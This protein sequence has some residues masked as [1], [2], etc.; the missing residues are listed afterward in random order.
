MVNEIEITLC[1]PHGKTAFPVVKVNEL[2]EDELY[3]YR[4]DGYYAMVSKYPDKL[5]EDENG[6][7]V[8]FEKSDGKWHARMDWDSGNN[9]CFYRDTLEEALLHFWQYDNKELITE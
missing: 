4:G 8:G 9:T 5:L 3:T 1:N 6:M 7:V 2:R